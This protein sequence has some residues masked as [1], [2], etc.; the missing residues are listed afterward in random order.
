MGVPQNRWFIRENP[1]KMDDLGVPLFMGNPHIHCSKVSRN[2]FGLHFG[3]E[4]DFENLVRQMAFG[5]FLE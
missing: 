5:G 2:H 3:E 4:E 1:I